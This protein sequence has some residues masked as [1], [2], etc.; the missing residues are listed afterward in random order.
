[1]Y[2][3]YPSIL[4][5]FLSV[6]SNIPIR[7]VKMYQ[8][9]VKVK[10]IRNDGCLLAWM[11]C[12]IYFFWSF[13]KAVSTLLTVGRT[14]QKAVLRS[15][16]IL[17]EMFFKTWWSNIYKLLPSCILNQLKY[18]INANLIQNKRIRRAKV[19]SNSLIH[20]INRHNLPI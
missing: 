20:T 7:W 2:W 12:Y 14:Q 19:D 6:Y 4:G 1:M 8:R 10:C 16:S 18:R 17:N 9:W 5:L 11:N 13:Q 3:K 15:V